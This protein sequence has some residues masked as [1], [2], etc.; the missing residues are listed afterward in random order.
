MILSRRQQRWMYLLTFLFLLLQIALLVLGIALPYWFVEGALSPNKFHVTHLEGDV[1]NVSSS[2]RYWGLFVAQVT[3]GSS[4]WKSVSDVADAV[5]R[6]FR[7][8]VFTD[9]PE[10]QLSDWLNVYNRLESST[11]FGAALCLLVLA[12]FLMVAGVFVLATCLGEAGA[13]V[14]H[15]Y[16][17]RKRAWW[18]AMIAN[19]FGIALLLVVLVVVDGVRP[20]VPLTVM[21]RSDSTPV[22]IM[23]DTVFD[24]SV[25]YYLVLLSLYSACVTELCVYVLWRH[26]R[27][28]AKYGTSGPV[29]TRAN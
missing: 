23:T 11:R 28:D 13:A 26:Q 22:M 7:D 20:F 29:T 21:R 8:V 24:M 15:P 9:T 27:S 10:L 25:S 14:G 19:F 4:Q 1:S 16:V 18:A 5:R 3:Y 17:G 2:G 12:V 6:M